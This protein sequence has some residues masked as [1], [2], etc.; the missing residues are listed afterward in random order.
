MRSGGGMPHRIIVRSRGLSDHQR[1]GIFTSSRVP[2]QCGSR[3]RQHEA[4]SH[5]AR[6]K[7]APSSLRAS[8]GAEFTPMT[9]CQI[10]YERE[11]SFLFPEENRGLI[12]ACN[13]ERSQ[14]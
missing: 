1:C 7:K 11:T 8:D 2:K 3:H 5:Y 14:P 10:N 4:M 9:Y 6:N 12:A 13:Q